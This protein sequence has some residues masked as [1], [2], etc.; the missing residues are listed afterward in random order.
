MTHAGG[1]TSA[2]RATRFIGRDLPYLI[3]SGWRDASR[4]LDLFN[5]ITAQFTV[6][7]L[8]LGVLGM[9]RLAR[10]YPTLGVTT[11]V[12]YAAFFGFG[13]AYYGADRSILLLPMLIIQV[14]WITYAVYTF[15]EWLEKSV[16]PANSDLVRQVAQVAYVVLPA[17]LL[18]NIAGGIG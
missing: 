1:G 5:F 15:S 9:A 4:W 3:A 11:L 2:E 13:L 8:A 16:A 7:G 6:V 17:L 10:W 18:A 12:A 14:M